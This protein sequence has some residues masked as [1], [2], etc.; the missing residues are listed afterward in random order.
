MHFTHKHYEPG[1]TIAA[2]ATPPGEGGVAIVRIS[3]KC[4]F[5]VADEV[6]SGNVRS[7]TSHTAHFGKIHDKLGA[8]VDEVLLLVMK[9]PRSYTGEDTIEIHCHGGSLV[10]RKVLDTVLKA[11]ARAALPGEFTYRAY[12]NEKI[13][14]SQAEAVQALIGAKNELAMH[15]AKTQLEGALGKKIAS[16]QE[17]LFDIAAV[18]EAAVDFPEEGLEFLSL[19]DVVA[20]LEKSSK[21]IA[22]LQGTFRDGKILSEG[23]NLCLAGAPNVGKSSLMNALLQK[24]RAIVTPIAGTTRDLIED[25]LKLGGLHFRLI[26]TAGIRTTDEIIEQEG[27]RRSKS[28]IVEADLILLVLDATRPLET[29]DLLLIEQL[30]KEKTIAVWNKIDCGSN[31]SKVLPHM[32]NVSAKELIGID[33]LKEKIY[34]MIWDQGAPPKDEI[35]IT[36]VRHEQALGRAKTSLLQVKDALLSGGSPEFACID[37]REALVALGEVIG[38]DVQEE[39]LTAI[40]SKFCIGK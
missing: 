13:D 21:K 35:V 28:A 36:N 4:A 15:A 33:M 22:A 11:G 7:Y 17:E 5:A 14:L 39:I 25:D 30:P 34:E 9:G 32:V 40:F 3:G 26:D 31:I 2:V 19:E 20:I 18:L 8:V 29:E 1:D 38:K 16:L 10:T 37:M 24:E 27:I 23:I 6:F 12:L